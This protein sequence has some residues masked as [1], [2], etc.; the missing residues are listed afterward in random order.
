M[1]KPIL[2][3]SG[4]RV[5]GSTRRSRVKTRMTIM[6]IT[7]RFLRGFLYLPGRLLGELL[8]VLMITMMA[9]KRR[10]ILPISIGR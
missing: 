7:F 3:N 1:A 5:S 4:P 9:E 10:K 2:C 8:Q 6:M